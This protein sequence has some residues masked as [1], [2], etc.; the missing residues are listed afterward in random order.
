MPSEE[1]YAQ[2]RIGALAS[3]RL[4]DDVA[5][6][7]RGAGQRRTLGGLNFLGS[8]SGSVCLHNHSLYTQGCNLVLG[9]QKDSG[10]AGSSPPVTMRAR[11][12][13]TVGDARR[14]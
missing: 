13:A 10:P 12:S 9:H 8:Q 11:R 7:V 14:C 5:D 1:D 3:E 4:S 6:K 2:T